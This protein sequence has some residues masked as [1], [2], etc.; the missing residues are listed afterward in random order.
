MASQ[1]PP[2]LPVSIVVGIGTDV[3]VVVVEVSS[4]VVDVEVE[5]G[6]VLVEEVEVV[7]AVP[8]LVG[9]GGEAV[10]VGRVS[11]AWVRPR[12]RRVM[13]LTNIM[14]GIVW[15]MAIYT[16]LAGLSIYG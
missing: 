7:L 11:W 5:V 3:A 15:G 1:S 2:V 6:K 16:V 13:A 12:R 10:V 4:G 14:F 9:A 8:G